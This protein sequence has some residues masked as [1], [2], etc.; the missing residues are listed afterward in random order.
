M[1]C[2]GIGVNPY[3]S[4]VSLERKIAGHAL[5]LL[6]LQDAGRARTLRPSH[7]VRVRIHARAGVGGAWRAWPGGR[8][9]GQSAVGGPA[10]GGGERSRAAS[11]V[12]P[13]GAS[14]RTRWPA[15]RRQRSSAV[16]PWGLL[17]GRSAWRSRAGPLTVGAA[18]AVS[19]TAVA[20]AVAEADEASQCMKMMPGPR[21]DMGLPV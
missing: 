16:R 4:R 3:G 15:G 19:V 14:A 21:E 10:G 5:L 6:R 9:R 1:C 17:Q 13:S 11:A 12:P 2:V 18:V 8:M 7:W 20:E